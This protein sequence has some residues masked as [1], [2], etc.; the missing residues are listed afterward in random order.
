MKANPDGKIL[1]NYMTI[2]PAASYKKEP[3]S[4]LTVY[5]TASVLL[6]GKFIL[7]NTYLR[8]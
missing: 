6:R 3:W 8:K 7:L 1:Q 2:D 5:H 4:L